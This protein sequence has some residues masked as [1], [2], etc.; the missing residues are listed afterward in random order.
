[1]ELN[2]LTI[3][4]VLHEKIKWISHKI[5]ILTRPVLVVTKLS[6]EKMEQEPGMRF[7]AVTQNCAHLPLGVF[8]AF[9]LSLGGLL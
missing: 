2:L 1:M 7:Q 3:I 8:S 4:E 6:N 5:Y 9:S